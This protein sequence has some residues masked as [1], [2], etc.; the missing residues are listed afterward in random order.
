[1]INVKTVSQRDERRC[2]HDTALR[3]IR[4][5]NARSR[6]LPQSGLTAN[7]SQ[8]HKAKNGEKP[9]FTVL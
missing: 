6:L 5:G 8:A 9:E 4:G 2:G 7:V 3:S 1:L